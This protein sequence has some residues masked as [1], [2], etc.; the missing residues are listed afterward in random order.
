VAYSIGGTGAILFI[1]TSLMPGTGRLQLTGK[2]GEVIKESVEVAL[3]WVRAHAYVL[4]L[5]RHPDEDLMKNKNVH[6]H[7]PAGAVPKDGPSAGM[8]F[9]VGLISLF[10]ERR[11]P[12]TIAMTGEVSLR[13]K[14]TAVGGIKEKLIGALTAGVKTVLLPVQNKKEVRELPEEVKNGLQII[15]VRNI[16][17]GLKNVWPEWT[18]GD[19]NISTLESRL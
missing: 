10:S 1:E 11:V 18:I 3:T 9:T 19:E 7:C 16:W 6:V 2:L 17:E 15:F 12:S 14:V 4:G 13:G 5:T 8:A